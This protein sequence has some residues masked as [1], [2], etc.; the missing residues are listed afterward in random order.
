MTFKRSKEQFITTRSL[1][2]SLSIYLSISHIKITIFNSPLRIIAILP[3]ILRYKATK[4]FEENK[5]LKKIMLKNKT[6]FVGNLPDTKLV[7]FYGLRKKE[8]CIE[9]TY[10]TYIYPRK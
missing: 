2:L 3:M 10:N 9:S 4:F 5:N 1:F 6:C 7:T 8:K